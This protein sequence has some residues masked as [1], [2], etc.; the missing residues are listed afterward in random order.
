MPSRHSVTVAR[1]VTL[2]GASFEVHKP[3]EYP[4]RVVLWKGIPCTDPLRTLVDLASVGTVRVLDEALDRALAKRLVSFHG[5]EAELRRSSRQGRRGVGALRAAL[6]RR[7]VRGAPAP[8]VLESMV[9]RLLRS[10]GVEPS[11]TEVHVGPDGRYRVDVQLTERLVLEFDGYAYH[12]SP[13]QKA[14]DER[15]RNRLRL[16]GVTVLVY[17]WADVRRDGRRVLLEVNRA[18][19]SSRPW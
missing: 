7:G 18:R 13:E 3:T 5:I 1:S 15:R 2:R 14:E 17:T 4:A 10:A 6:D 12:H 16:A 11:G 9:L 19:A 8:S